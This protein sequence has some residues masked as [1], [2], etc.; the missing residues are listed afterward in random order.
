M[1][2][3]LSIPGWMS[4]HEL[5][6]LAKW[7]E[8]CETIIEIGSY[9]GRSAYALA[10][11]ESRA[12]V[13]CF[14]PWSNT[15]IENSAPSS[16]A[17][18]LENTKRVKNITPHRMA[19][20]PD[21]PLERKVDLVFLDA[22][23]ENPSDRDYIKFWLPR[24]KPGGYMSGHDWYPHGRYYPDVLENVRWLEKT[25]GKVETPAGSLWRFR[26]S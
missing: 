1:T 16:L 19:A 25:F 21:W 8:G 4:E 10:A 6:T 23:H 5:Q 9:L 3:D 7:A 2:Y 11:S 18:F 12:A 26:I 14:D 13:H 17:A 22:V 15:P 24:I 20:L